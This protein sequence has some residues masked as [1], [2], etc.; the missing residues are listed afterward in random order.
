MVG[1]LFCCSCGS[2]TVNGV[3]PTP[4][5]ASTPVSAS[6]PLA[7]TI[8]S[9]PGAKAGTSYSASLTATGGTP[10]YAW[11]ISSGSLPAGLSLSS[12]GVISGTP[13][14][15][16][17]G[18][19]SV[20]AQDSASSP[21]AATQ[22]ESISV[23][24]QAENISVSTPGFYVSP[25]G[26][27]A[28]PGTLAAPFATFAQ[29]QAAMQASST[30]KTTYIRAGSYTLPTIS[31]CDGSGNSCG[32]SLN[33]ADNG[34]TWSYYPPD[35][36]DSASLSGG[37]TAAGTGLF[38]AI[39]VTNT[40]GLIINGLS[41]HN[42]Q[43]A[44]IGSMGGVS[45]LT[46]ENNII[47]N[48]YNTAS[49]NAGGFQCYGCADTKISY[50]VVHDIASFGIGLS[51]V[52]GD[53][54][55]LVVTG[56]VLYNICTG[57][58]DC[59][60]I[61]LYDTAQ[62]ATNISWTNNYIRDGNTTGGSGWGSALYLDDCT[63]NVTA[64]GNIITG[65][66]GGNTVMIHSGYNNHFTGNF[67]DLSTYGNNTLTVQTTSCPNASM[68]GNEY[69]HNIVISNGAGSGY[70]SL[71]GTPPTTQTVT[72]NDYYN[73]G[74]GTISTSGNAG[75]DSTPTTVNPQVS[76]WLYTVASG[77][78]VFSSPVDFP[79]MAG[80]WGPPGYTIPQTGSAPSSPH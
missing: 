52:N 45:N 10:P 60:A 22:T 24:N 37:S 79:T 25:T 23:A 41:I 42:F 35:G 68:S 71:S 17:T 80:G 14:T 5:G 20:T 28:N 33:S 64:T 15:V 18:V 74:S 48:G 69:E 31:N 6:T 51:N 54:S 47:F 16:G 26:N 21:Q 9:L 12:A 32:L 1:L 11:S 43:Y 75:S 36:Y 63:S 30:I 67:T 65:K 50:N 53:V 39:Y 57:V 7:M 27:D 59:G 58:A 44:G 77:S 46:V 13:T 70:R 73:Y 76:G 66:N 49:Q 62:T 34:E 19:F 56:N 29:A 8:T 40:N 4:A 78:P 61:Y 55:N 72:G 3:A 2:K 38:Y